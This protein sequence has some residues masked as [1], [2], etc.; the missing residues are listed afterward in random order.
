MKPTATNLF[1]QAA[2]L[3]SAVAFVACSQ[4]AV[5]TTSCS[6]VSSV[7]SGAALSAASTYK[8]N[9]SLGGYLIGYH[10]PTPM[11]KNVDPSKYEKS[12]CAV[13]SMSDQFVPGQ[14]GLWTAT[15]CLDL[16]RLV[17]L[18]FVRYRPNGSGVG[19][20]KLDMS[21]DHVV[22]AIQMARNALL[23][24]PENV[25]S[26]LMTMAFNTTESS[27]TEWCKSFTAANRKAGTQQICSSLFDL[28]YISFPIPP[29][30]QQGSDLKA[31][32]AELRAFPVLSATNRAKQDMAR[33]TLTY[34]EIGELKLKLGYT[35]LR[36]QLR[37][38]DGLSPAAVDA[39]LCA[40]KP[41]IEQLAA[42]AFKDLVI[43]N[44]ENEASATA[45][46]NEKVASIRAFAQS[47]IASSDN[48]AGRLARLYSLGNFSLGGGKATTISGL[49]IP[50]STAYLNLPGSFGITG[51]DINRV[52]ILFGEQGVLI[53]KP[54]SLARVSFAPGDSGTLVTYMLGDGIYAP[55]GAISTINGAP[56]SGGLAVHPS[57]EGAEGGGSSGSATTSS[58]ANPGKLTTEGTG[59]S[60]QPGGC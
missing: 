52:E 56:T 55:V 9:Q 13:S 17:K 37:A 5:S 36:D 14:V 60:G 48:T 46:L 58:D 41:V 8:A 11:A 47:F 7:V 59:G 12:F 6:K 22:R 39:A 35:R 24:L 57:E 4:G 23:S 16:S 29:E 32:L 42:L 26:K 21:L 34:K 2:L 20:Y 30:A 28:A 18:E 54:E 45:A 40:S 44:D 27:G 53:T 10:L 25:S 43:G 15:H 51:A 38:C 31:L 49:N 50:G 19:T 33:W 1:R 3:A